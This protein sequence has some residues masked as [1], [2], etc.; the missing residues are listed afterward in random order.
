MIYNISNFTDANNL[1]EA[2]QAVD[3]LSEGLFGIMLFVSLLAVFFITFRVNSDADN[4]AIFAVVFWFGVLWGSLLLV[5]DILPV[6]IV[7]ID[8]FFA[9]F[10]LG[11]LYWN[12]R[13]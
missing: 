4:A 7:V 11:Y 10:S 1:A 6:E 8:V 3:Q 9:T 2:L 13:N 5:L 12:Q